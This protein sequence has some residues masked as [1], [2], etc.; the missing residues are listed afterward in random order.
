MHLLG[1]IHT[2]YDLDVFICFVLCTWV[3]NYELFYYKKSF[4]KFLISKDTIKRKITN[5]D[6]AYHS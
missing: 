5:K 4:S 6:I 2:I 1:E 3:A